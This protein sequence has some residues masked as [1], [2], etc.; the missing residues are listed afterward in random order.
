MAH[1]YV[2]H[3]KKRSDDHQIHST[4]SDHDAE[5][6]SL[7]FGDLEICGMQWLFGTRKPLITY[8]AVLQ[9]LSAGTGM[10]EK[11]SIASEFH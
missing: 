4:I 2:K 9:S 5:L 7:R 3:D 11:E 6:S 10:Q 8:R 1:V